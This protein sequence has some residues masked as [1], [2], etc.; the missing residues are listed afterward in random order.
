M[1]Q[2]EIENEMAKLTEAERREIAE[3]EMRNDFAYTDGTIGRIQQ[4][5]NQKRAA[6]RE[7]RAGKAA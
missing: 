6:L 3:A 2:R 5:Y 1:T 7:A 4:A